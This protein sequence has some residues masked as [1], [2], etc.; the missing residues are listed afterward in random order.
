MTITT[1]NENGR[2]IVAVNGRIDTNT[3]PQLQSELLAAFQQNNSITLDLAEVAYVSSAGL[4][5]LLIAQKTAA[6]KKAT[7]ELVNVAPEVMNVLDSVGFSDI[8]VIV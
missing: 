3:S 4:R 2:L 1:Q 6:S 7:F 5:V 8:L